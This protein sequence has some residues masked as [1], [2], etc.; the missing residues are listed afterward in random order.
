VVTVVAIEE[1]AYHAV[2]A[3]VAHPF[4]EPPYRI[5]GGRVFFVYD[6][7]KAMEHVWCD[8]PV[9]LAPLAVVRTFRTVGEAER[10]IDFLAMIGP[11]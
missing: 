7:R 11:R 3:D 2:P 5:G 4:P 8:N 9:A 10:W 6:T 1:T